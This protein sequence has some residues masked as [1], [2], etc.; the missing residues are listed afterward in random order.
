MSARILLVD[1]DPALRD[2]LGEV[3][4]DEGYEVRLAANGREGLHALDGWRADLVLLDL[5]MPEMGAYAFRAV[6]RQ[7]ERNPSPV[8]I[9]SAA[10]GL[11]ATGADLDAV[12]V[13]GKPFRLE[14]LL[15]LIARILRGETVHAGDA[16]EGDDGRTQP[17]TR[18]SH[19]PDPPAQS[20]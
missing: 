15:S 1:D 8:L 10:P 17:A 5:M 2:A 3:L 4:T 11:P 18:E 20:G 19:P 13:V 9:L 14:E 6:Q 12:A 16:A 7:R